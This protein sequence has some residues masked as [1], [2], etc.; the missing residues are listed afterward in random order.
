MAMGGDD[1]APGLEVLLSCCGGTFAGAVVATQ[2][3]RKRK[4]AQ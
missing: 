1:L 3:A 2:I 4:G